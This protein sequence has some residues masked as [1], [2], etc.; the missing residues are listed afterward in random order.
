MATLMVQTA[1]ATT[2]VLLALALSRAALAL[3]LRAAFGRLR[4]GAPER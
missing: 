1:A 2:S 3:V 4:T